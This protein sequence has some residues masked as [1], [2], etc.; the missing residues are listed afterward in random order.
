ME[1]T[2]MPMVKSWAI[3]NEKLSW[4]PG[5][6]RKAAVDHFR[7]LTGNDCLRSHLYRIGIAYLPDCTLCYS[8][9]SITSEHLVV[10][11]A[12]ISLN[13]IVEKYWRA[14]ALMA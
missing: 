4:V 12:L 8:D 9:Q 5:A 13:S 10:C 6:P 1:V 7:L 3:F 14:R 11:P 2:E